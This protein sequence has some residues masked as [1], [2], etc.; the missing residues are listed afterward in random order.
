MLVP[1]LHTLACAI[2]CFLLVG[3]A[4]TRVK[5]PTQ[6][7]LTNS[8]IEAVENGVRSIRHDLND[9]VF[10]GFRAARHEDGQIDVCGWV[11]PNRSSF[12]R[13]F[14][15]TLFAGTFAAERLGGNEVDNAEILSDCH[16]R[17]VG[18]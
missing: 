8:E 18:I 12:E 15:G 4:T 16:N 7:A 1:A 2:A 14:I 6:Y 9:P 13:P 11:T 10:R 3:C 17:G 5:P